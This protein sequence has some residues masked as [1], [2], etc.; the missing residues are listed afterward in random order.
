MRGDPEFWRRLMTDVVLRAAIAALAVWVVVGGFM[1][2]YSAIEMMLY[3]DNVVGALIAFVMM[4]LAAVLVLDVLM[5]M[6]PRRYRWR[7]LDVHRRHV[8][9][10]A[11]ACYVIPPFVLARLTGDSLG[12]CAPWLG[13]AV[14]ALLMAFIDQHEKRHRGAKCEI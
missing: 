13:V 11:A 6:V 4:G 12:S 14:A 5:N 2:P 3:V 9:V 7:W 10:A 1:M 8:Y